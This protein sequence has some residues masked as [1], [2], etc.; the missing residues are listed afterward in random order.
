MVHLVKKHPHKEGIFLGKF[1]NM[2]IIS[3]FHPM[4]ALRF[5]SVVLTFS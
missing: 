5:A 4:Q 3:P 2:A 1:N